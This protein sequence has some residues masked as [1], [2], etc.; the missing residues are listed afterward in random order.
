MSGSQLS[1]VFSSKPWIEHPLAST[2]F[3]CVPA[4]SFRVLSGS[5]GLDSFPLHPDRISIGSLLAQ[6]AES[7]PSSPMP[8]LSPHRLLRFATLTLAITLAR[9]ADAQTL[10]RPGWAG[11]GMG[12]APWWKHAAIYQADPHGF[13]GLHGLAT[14]LDYVHSI[15]V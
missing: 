5:V 2:W 7:S 13:G 3:K 12:A 15:G 8:I 9:T 10:A 14:H 6:T 11:S 4:G 1:A